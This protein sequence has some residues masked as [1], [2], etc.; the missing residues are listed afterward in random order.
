MRALWDLLQMNLSSNDLGPLNVLWNE[1]IP[2]LLMRRQWVSLD[3][4]WLI[5]LVVLKNKDQY[6]KQID[7]IMMYHDT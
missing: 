5:I 7:G 4:L 3:R 2:L 1:T 6:L